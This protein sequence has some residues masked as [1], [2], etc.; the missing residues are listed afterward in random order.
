[1]HIEFQ[2][3][4]PVLPWWPWRLVLALLCG[5]C[6]AS[7]ELRKVQEAP[8]VE[9]PVL[10]GAQGELS[11]ARTRAVLEVLAR[12]GQGSELLSRHLAVE[13]ALSQTPL[14]IGNEVQLLRDG[15]ATY[16][17]MYE[18]IRDARHH[19]NMETYI[20]R[21]DEIGHQVAELLVERRHQG[22]VVN[23]I[24]DSVGSMDTPRDFFQRL[25]AEGV[26]VLEFNPVDPTRARGDW[27][28][29]H[30][31]HRKVLI[32]D[33]R[34]A[35]TGGINVD[36]V[37][38]SGSLSGSRRK[39]GTGQT[40][41]RDTDIRVEGPAVA[42]FQKFFLGT[43]AKQNGPA[44]Q[45]GNY[46]PRLREPGPAI[47]RAIG[48]SPDSTESASQAALL[49][50]IEHAERSVHITN[51]YFVP[52]ERLLRALEGAARAGVEVTLVLP[53]HSDV[54]P[55]LYAGR[56]KYARL[57][58]AGVSIYERKA[59]LLHAKT[60]V[61][62]GVW[63]TVGSTNLDRRSLVSNDE[64]D[65]IVLGRAF[66]NQMEAMFRDDLRESEQITAERWARRSVASRLKELSAVLFE[67]WL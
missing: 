30:R 60:A 27:A 46:F 12:Q 50:A 31:D 35:I 6:A 1:M 39:P 20:F 21:D 59:A 14:T 18:A 64:L 45:D 16:R 49:S 61:I 8:A 4:H 56:A 51:A 44:L 63:S 52:D 7:P 62:D 34:I 32:V 5:G 19:I 11:P 33:G 25:A 66:G 41:W 2:K 28:L 37:Y 54:W 24:Y 38:S 43:W 23:L 29:T 10:V 67:N 22:V 13:Q 26:N 36:S 58:R 3:L 17:A 9:P 40:P 53:S 55:A 15:A 47:V 42:Q 65:T 48:T 57:L